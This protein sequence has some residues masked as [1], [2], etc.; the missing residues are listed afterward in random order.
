VLFALRQITAPE[1]F[2]PLAVLRDSVVGSATAAAF[3]ANGTTVALTVFVALYFQLALGVSA[4]RPGIAIIAFQGGAPLAA[5]MTGRSM[6]RIVHYKR[7]PVAS[8]VLGVLSLSVL[9]AWPTQLPLAAVVA[10]VALMGCGIGPVFPTT[11]VAI[12][13]A[14]S[15]H[16][17]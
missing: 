6:A 17:L 4:G 8:L 3:F 12:Q 16:Q 9:A 2:I 7:I 13:N 1:P 5:M 11:I 10:I 14:V 15:L